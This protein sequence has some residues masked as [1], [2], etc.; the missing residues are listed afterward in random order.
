MTFAQLLD[1]ALG[2]MNDGSRQGINDAFTAFQ[3]SLDADMVAY[4]IGTVE[5]QAAQDTLL[6]FGRTLS[7]MLRTRAETAS[8]AILAESGHILTAEDGEALLLET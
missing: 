2:S 3:S 7:A 4:G 8:G 1:R 5:R 6:E